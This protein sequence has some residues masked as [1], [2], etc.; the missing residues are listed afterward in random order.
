MN[1]S[2]ILLEFPSRKFAPF[3]LVINQLCHVEAHY[4]ARSNGGFE[5]SCLLLLM[6]FAII[7]HIN[8]HHLPERLSLVVRSLLPLPLPQVLMI[9][10]R[11]YAVISPRRTDATTNTIV[12]IISKVELHPR[13]LR[14]GAQF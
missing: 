2:S 5:H 7:I 8:L 1:S 13:N 11:S 12:M 3:F 6:R 9:R 14:P 4:R 10:D